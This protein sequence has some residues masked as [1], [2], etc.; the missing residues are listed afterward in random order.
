MKMK[1]KIYV[2]MDC[3]ISEYIIEEKTK[4]LAYSKLIKEQ[5][6]KGILEIRS[7]IIEEKFWN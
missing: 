7:K 3:N 2:N 1:F 6:L 4:I 5:K